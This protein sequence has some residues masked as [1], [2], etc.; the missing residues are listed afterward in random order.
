M[1]LVREGL[2]YIVYLLGKFRELFR[3]FVGIIVLCQ[4]RQWSI[5]DG[6]FLPLEPEAHYEA[7]LYTRLN[8]TESAYLFQIVT[9]RITLK[10]IFYAVDMKI[11]L[12]LVG[13]IG[14]Y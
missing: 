2:K 13:V 10:N 5:N 14:G 3:N 6:E 12:I 8:L 4:A 11:I 7:Y 9:S 1:L